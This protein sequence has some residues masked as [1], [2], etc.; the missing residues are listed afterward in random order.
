[1][2]T[3]LFCYSVINTNLKWQDQFSDTVNI[4]KILYQSSVAI[5]G[6]SLLI[7]TTNDW[8]GVEIIATLFRNGLSGLHGNLAG[9]SRPD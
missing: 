2:V 5:I 9:F 3:I 7:F 1:M 6:T 8:D 4:S